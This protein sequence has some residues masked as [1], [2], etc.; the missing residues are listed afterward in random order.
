MTWTWEP[1]TFAAHWFS[2][3]DDRMP[4]PLRYRSRF[5]TRDELDGHR[6]AVRANGDRDERERIDLLMHTV[7]RC[8][9]RVEIMGSTVRHHRGDGSTHKQYRIIGAYTGQYA[10]LLF[11]TAIHGVFGDIRA[12]LLRPEDLPGAMVATVP[13]CPPGTGRPET[14]HLDDITPHHHSLEPDARHTEYA[15]FRRLTDRPAD[16]GGT[17]ILRLGNYHARPLRH[18]VVQWYDI[19]GDGRYVEQ[20]NSTHLDIRPTT[21]D[22][23]TGIFTSWID[24]ATKTLRRTEMTRLP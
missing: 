8:E 9:L 12:D 22:K 7:A 18:R 16:G 13:P 15:R 19:T 24:N 3:V 21:A 4:A 10:A 20:R 14:F 6:A 23:L 2:H 11:Q 1:D 5:P 17:A